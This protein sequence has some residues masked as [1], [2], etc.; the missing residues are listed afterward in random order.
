MST[1]VEL[2]KLIPNTKSALYKYHNI[3]YQI[4]KIIFAIINIELA[5]L[6]K[7]H[8]LIY[9]SNFLVVVLSISKRLTI[10]LVHT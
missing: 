9:I 6:Y 4:H 2:V 3:L 5:Y 7:H 10:C 1:Q 8:T